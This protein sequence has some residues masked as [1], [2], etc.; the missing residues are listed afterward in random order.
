MARLYKMT[1]YICDLGEDTYLEEIKR[2]IE[3]NALDRVAT[4]CICHFSDEKVVPYID[5][6]DSIDLNQSECSTKEW[7]DYFL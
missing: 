6:H 1:L 5:W 4:N 3:E 2:S 7:E